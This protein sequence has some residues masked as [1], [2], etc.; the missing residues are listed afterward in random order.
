M[1]RFLRK[2]WHSIPVG[3][4]T[5]VLAMCLVAGGVFAAYNFFSATVDVTVEE[6]F[7]F[8]V[9]YVGWEA[10]EGADMVGGYYSQMTPLTC[11]VAL[12]AGESSNGNPEVSMPEREAL[13]CLTIGEEPALS[14]PSPYHT[15]NSMQVANDAALPITVSFAVTGETENVYMVWWGEEDGEP[16]VGP[17]NGHTEEVPGNGFIMKGIGVVAEADAIP[18]TYSFTVTVNR[19]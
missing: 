10:P 3:I 18:G 5:A 15:F 7:T 19:G 14:I 17:L 16:I 4:I 1:R 2:R 6:P 11:S 12:M 9:N 13:P 8:G